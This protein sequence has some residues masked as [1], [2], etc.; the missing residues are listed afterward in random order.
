MTGHGPARRRAGALLAALATLAA[1]TL[2]PGPTSAQDNADAR[3]AIDR[4]KQLPGSVQQVREVIKAANFGPFQI[5]GSC[6]YNGVWYC[7]WTNCT[8]FTWSWNFPNYTWLRSALDQRFQTIQAVSSQFEGR[9]APVRAWLLDTLPALGSTLEASTARLEQAEATLRRPD[10][11]AAELEAARREIEQTIEAT[12]AAL[13]QGSARL[14]DGLAGLAAFNE[15]L[16]AV[17][18]P[19]E[20]E[21]A[22]M[23]QMI[24][25]DERRLNDEIGGWPCGTDGARNGYNG[26][27]TTVRTQFQNVMNA[28]QAFGVTATKTDE[29]VSQ[30]LGRLLNLVNAHQQV[31]DSLRSAQV[32]PAGAVQQLRLHMA[33]SAWDELASYARRELGG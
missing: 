2:G 7:L 10:A 20:D 12:T 13:R 3:V 29:S 25:S 17:L 14:Q 32:T 21:R 27:R 23:E 24:A 5:G 28:S 1:L 31:L 26:I 9:F 19:L 33:A 4:L 22:G 6:N 15:Q 16:K 18:Q 11:S 30:I 8:T